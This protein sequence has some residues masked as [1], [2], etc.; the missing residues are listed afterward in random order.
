M[1]K[2]FYYKLLV[3]CIVLIFCCFACGKNLEK[4]SKKSDPDVAADDDFTQGIDDGG[5]DDDNDA[6][7][8]DDNND[9]DDS[10]PPPEPDYDMIFEGFGAGATGG[11]QEGGATE[12]V[13]SFD[14]D[15]PGTLRQV[16]RD[17]EGQFAND[18]TIN[19]LS[20]LDLPSN[21]TIDARGRNITVNGNG[22]RI[23]EKNNIIL[24]NL[25][26]IDV[27]GENGDCI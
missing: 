11:G 19:L 12:T 20:V 14:D 23:Q 8:D 7:D 2:S 21:L 18:G 6:D 27:V 1:K 24:M 13:T 17:V 10:T 3:L 5:D 25:A 26:F 16:L 22:F 4:N 15:G 9:D